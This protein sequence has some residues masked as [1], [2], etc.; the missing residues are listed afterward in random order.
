MSPG[1]VLDVQRRAQRPLQFTQL[2]R[3]QRSHEVRQRVLGRLTNSSQ[4]ALLSCLSPSP[5]PTATWAE[6][7]SYEEWIGAQITVENRRLGQ[8]L[9]THDDEHA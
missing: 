5:I 8:R 1:S 2:P 7:R 9:A 6:S 3:R 4:W